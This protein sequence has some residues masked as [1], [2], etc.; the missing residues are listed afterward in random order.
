MTIVTPCLNAR[1]TIER[2]LDSIFV[3]EYENLEHIIVDGGS[4]D[5]TRELLKS[6]E[7][8]G[9][10]RLI[11]EP[12]DGLADALNKG[13]RL[14]D[15]E[16]IGLLNA[17]DLYLPGSLERVAAAFQANPKAWWVTGSC[18]IID[19]EDREIRR[20]I[21]AYKNFLLRHYTYRVLLTQCFVS[22]PSTFFKKGAF[23]EVGLFDKSLS[24]A[25]D[26]DLCLRLGRHRAP[27]ILR[28]LPL[29]AF[30]MAGETLSLT[31][32][33]RQFAEGR[34]LARRYAGDDSLAVIGSDVMHTGIEFAYRVLRAVRDR[35]VGRRG[36]S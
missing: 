1:A 26:Y 6:L 4:T 36:T 13:V 5:G 24:Y 20:P 11:A 7:S 14:A 29:A 3:Q 16:I 17:D 10:I 21:T 32:F 34:R 27:I 12:D 23:D 8:E 28:G 33:D 9:C 15:S 30:R 35:R 18:I 2:T 25:V 31:G 22:G 19:G